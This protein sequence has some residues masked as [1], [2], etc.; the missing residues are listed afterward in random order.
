[1][2]SAT[3]ICVSGIRPYPPL[4]NIE[5]PA[6]YINRDRDTERHEAIINE[7]KRAGIEGN[8]IEAVEGL[9]V[10]FALKSYFLDKD[11]AVGRMSAG[12]V[13]CYASHLLALRA[14]L[15]RDLDYALI[16]EDD[17][18]LSTNI[19]SL[20]AELVAVLPRNWD[21]VHL[22][23]DVRR[24]VKPLRSLANGRMLIRYSRIPSGTVGYLVSRHGAERFLAPRKRYWPIDTDFRRPWLFQLDTYGVSPPPIDHCEHLP[25]AI[26][27]LGG[28][29]RG[30]RG[31]PIPS[32]HAWTGN[33]LHCPEGALYNLGVLGL[34]DWCRCMLANARNRWGRSSSVKRPVVQASR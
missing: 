10:P 19:R 8:R 12:E 31:V 20:V 2:R 3:S 4:G 33:P 9:A 28:R 13:G 18:I 29:A 14:L 15:T 6:F 26:Q 27:M 5:V 34:G 11:R 25:S 22:S 23:G 24:A 32:V 16:V 7:F 30:R 17:A 1:M 21:I